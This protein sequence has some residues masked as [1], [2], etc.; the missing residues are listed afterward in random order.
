MLFKID[1]K[2][3]QPGFNPEFKMDHTKGYYDPTT[4]HLKFVN[5]QERTYYLNL[6]PW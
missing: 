4:M 6:S 2:Y 1:S 5:G 3:I